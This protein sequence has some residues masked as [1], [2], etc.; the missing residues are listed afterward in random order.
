[1]GMLFV[2]VCELER[3]LGGLRF[4]EI[5]DGDGWGTH[6][7]RLANGGS[8]VDAKI[9]VAGSLGHLAVAVWVGS[10][11]QHELSRK[12]SSLII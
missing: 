5:F 1:M 8:N 3:R 6:F 11:Q 9:L 10:V 12:D 4:L 2:T 7:G